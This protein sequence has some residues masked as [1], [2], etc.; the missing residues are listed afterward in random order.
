MKIRRDLSALPLRS[1]EATCE[2]IVD[3]VTGPDSNDIDQLAAAAPAVASLIADEHYAE[4][5]LTLAGVGHRLLIYLRYGAAALEAGLAVDGLGW[6][7]TAG[8]WTLHV[9]CEAEALAWA[10]AHL[11]EKASRVV[12]YELSSPLPGGAAPTESVQ[13]RAV[14]RISWGGSSA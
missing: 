12:L 3:L 1:G 10:R 6:N 8:D 5:P 4:H 7:P 13:K 9:P 14:P 11:Q 2:A